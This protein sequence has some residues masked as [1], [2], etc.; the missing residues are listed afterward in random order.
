MAQEHEAGILRSARPIFFPVG[1]LVI[2]Q[3]L[4]STRIPVGQKEGYSIE[5]SSFS[6]FLCFFPLKSGSTYVVLSG[7]FLFIPLVTFMQL[8]SL[9]DI[10]KCA[11]T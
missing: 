3:V 4:S 10:Y 6:P 8:P 9:S 11:I 2:T 5:N 1:I 7:V